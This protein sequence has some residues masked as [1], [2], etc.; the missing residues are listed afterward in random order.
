MTKASVRGM[1][2][3]QNFLTS[4]TAPEEIQALQL[5]PSQFFLGGASKRGWTTWTTASV[6]QRLRYNYIITH[7]LT[8]FF[9]GYWNFTCC[10]G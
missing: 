10:D 3:I 8:R 6:D 7:H 5:Y 1:D 2:T 4:D 9:Q